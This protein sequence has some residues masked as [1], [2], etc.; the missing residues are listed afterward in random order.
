[1]LNLLKFMLRSFITPIVLTMIVLPLYLIGW[2]TNQTEF[3]VALVVAG[4]LGQMLQY[5]TKERGKK[6]EGI[7]KEKKKEVED[8]PKSKPLPK[9]VQDLI[10]E[11]ESLKS[12]D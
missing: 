12:E 5:W 10:A 4:V 9:E 3:I 7:K 8:V 1:M 2:I 6:K 11:A